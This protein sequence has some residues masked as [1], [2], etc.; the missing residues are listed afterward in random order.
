MLDLISIFLAVSLGALV[1]YSAG[2]FDLLGKIGKKFMPTKPTKAKRLGRNAHRDV[3]EAEEELFYADND[4]K[5][6]HKGEMQ[7]V[8]YKLTSARL[9]ISLAR[10]ILTALLGQGFDEDENGNNGN[11]NGHEA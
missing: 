1:G 7:N 5:P 6:L 2:R 11:G 3:T 10:R 9:H 4:L 8:G